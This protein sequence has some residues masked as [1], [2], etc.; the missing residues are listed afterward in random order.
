MSHDVDDDPD[1]CPDCGLGRD[2]AEETYNLVLGYF[3]S[4]GDSRST[5]ELRIEFLWM[6]AARLKPGENLPLS[7][8]QLDLFIEHMRHAS[9]CDPQDCEDDGEDDFA[10]DPDESEEEDPGDEDAQSPE[11][12]TWSD[13]LNGY[14]LFWSA[15]VLFGIIF[16]IVWAIYEIVEPIC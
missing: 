7:S 11:K 12:V 5:A 10:S 14:T 1:A 15:V 3:T 13:H 9:F 6:H 8:S 4:N 2:A 16:W